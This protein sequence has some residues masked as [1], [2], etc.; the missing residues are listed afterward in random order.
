MVAIRLKR[1]GAHHEPHYRI[2]VS[3]SRK[4]PSGAFIESIGYYD[5]HTEP[6]TVKMNLDR[7]Q[8]WISKGAKP[9]SSVAK[10]IKRATV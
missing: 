10:L 3:D 1:V 8:H 5:P 9:S 6:I 4:D 7:V 2:V